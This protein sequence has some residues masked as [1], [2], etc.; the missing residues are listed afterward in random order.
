MKKSDIERIIKKFINAETISYLITGVLTTLVDYAVFFIVNEALKR[1]GVSVSLSSSAATAAGW[2]SAVLFAYVTNK[3]YVFKSR[4]K[5]RSIILREMMSFF[6][7]RALSGLIVLV[8]MWL[9]VDRLHMN[10]YISKIF[11]SV[12]NVVFNYAASKLF[13]FKKKEP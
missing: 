6:A 3:I 10:E 8:L 4:S 5:D 1:T 13:I 2:F 11:T 7:A 9:M 12:F